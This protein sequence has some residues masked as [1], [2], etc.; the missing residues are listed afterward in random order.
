MENIIH[1]VDGW[2]YEWV[3]THINSTKLVYLHF[4]KNAVLI[5]KILSLCLLLFVYSQGYSQ[6]KEATLLKKIRN[7][8]SDTAK[9]NLYN[10]LA[11]EFATL[12][13]AKTFGY[14]DTAF[15]ISTKNNYNKGKADAYFAKAQYFI[16]KN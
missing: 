15:L 13:S 8:S 14:A 9:A 12:D 16:A 4:N 11:N 10:A 3:T 1:E 2:N 6:N 7:T 5:K